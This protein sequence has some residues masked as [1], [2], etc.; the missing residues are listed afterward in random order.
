M[1]REKKI[2][3][4]V[5]IC[6]VFIFELHAQ[7][8]F[9]PEKPKLVVGIIVD[10]FKADYIQRYWEKYSENGFKKIINSGT[11]FQNHVNKQLINESIVCYANIS[12]G[13]YASSHGIIDT[14]YFD[15][16][17]ENM[18]HCSYSEKQKSLNNENT[19]QK[20]NSIQMLASA[21]SDE[22]KYTTNKQSKIVSIA[23][24]APAASIMAGH[25]SGIALWMDYSS[26]K[27]TSSAYF[28]DSL[29]K[30]LDAFNQKNLADI[31]LNKQWTSLLSLEKYT[32]SLADNDEYE[33][34][35]GRFHKEFPYD[36]SKISLGKDKYAI[37][38]ET[39]FGISFSKDL[40]IQA[41]IEENMGKDEIP[42]L[43][44]LSITSGEGISARFH[45]LSVETEDFFLRLD[46]EIAHLITFIESEIG[47][48]NTLIFL[49]GTHGM[50]LPPEYMAK[51][52][53]DVDYFDPSKI[54]GILTSYLKAIYGKGDWIQY[55][56]HQQMYLNRELI[57]K[58]GFSLGDFQQSITDF[59]VQVS[60][61]SQA[62]GSLSLENGSATGEYFRNLQNSYHQKRSADIFIN[63][64]PGWV[65]RPYFK[66]EQRMYA[67]NSSY[68]YNAH[69]PLIWY[70]WKIKRKKIN[71]LSQPIDIAPTIA[72]FLMLSQPNASQG[73]PLNDIILQEK[74]K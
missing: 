47:I 56:N 11:H 50:A 49:T 46:Q 31:Y 45:P 35:F 62:V 66:D 26:G 13:S 30:W 1:I 41:I 14:E 40:A 58:S 19:R 63:L 2:T 39:P 10:G 67:H 34:G 22:L 8:K 43:L 55:Y 20:Y 12:T 73:T 29:P 51:Q 59:L 37:L 42:D 69:I 65:E 24:D 60:G 38:N 21:L 61:I 7:P 32:E 5:V 53:F 6:I 48:E 4:L 17:T 44:Y 70:G 15:R 23:M 3:L 25:K 71:S 68:M 57:R 64:S 33:R 74:P 18:V 54:I 72:N 9:P 28:N 52:G 16:L 27:W 36:L